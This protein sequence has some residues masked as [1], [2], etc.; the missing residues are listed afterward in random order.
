MQSHYHIR[1]DR[2]EKIL[3]KKIKKINKYKVIILD[4]DN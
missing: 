2:E 1:K 3:I 4:K